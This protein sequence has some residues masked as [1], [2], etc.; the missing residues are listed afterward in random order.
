MTSRFGNW[1]R[2]S[3]TTRLLMLVTAVLMLMAITHVGA[4]ADT[5]YVRQS[6]QCCT[7]TANNFPSAGGIWCPPGPFATNFCDPIL[8]ANEW[9]NDRIASPMGWGWQEG[10]F[11][12]STFS[13]LCEW[14]EITCN[15]S[16]CVY[17][18][19]YSS[20]Y[21]SDFGPPIGDPDCEP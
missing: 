3:V 9:F 12:E 15:G 18:S 13:A 8:G 2:S 16:T 17:A 5:C 6:K 7:L 21:C 1:T 11:E 10:S 20:A 14:K 19:N 4:V